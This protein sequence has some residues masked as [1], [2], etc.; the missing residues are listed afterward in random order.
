M[1]GA[2]IHILKF[3]LSTEK[4]KTFSDTASNLPHDR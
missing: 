2:P 1:L 4:L 3:P